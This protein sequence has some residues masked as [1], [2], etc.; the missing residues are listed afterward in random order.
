M[1]FVFQVRKYL[2]RTVSSLGCYLQK[3]KLV[4]RQDFMVKWICTS[5]F[6]KLSHQVNW[7]QRGV[8]Q[9]NNWYTHNALY[10]INSYK[11]N[12][13][14]IRWIPTGDPGIFRD[15]GS[16]TKTQ[17]FKTSIVQ[18]SSPQVNELS[19]HETIRAQTG[20]RFSIIIHCQLFSSS[21]ERLHQY[22]H[23]EASMERCSFYFHWRHGRPQA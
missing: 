21:M 9:H 7:K 18:T 13:D 12:K 20:Q 16:K 8:L 19:E 14:K 1:R 6:C 17:N 2:N 23:P 11:N 15:K 5:R 3:S 22:S 4:A 10:K